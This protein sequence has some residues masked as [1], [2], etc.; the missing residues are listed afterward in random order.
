MGGTMK[1]TQIFV[2]A[3]IPNE[4]VA[5]DILTQAT[6]QVST[7]QAKLWEETLKLKIR[8]CPK[9]MPKFIYKKILSI[10]LYQEVHR[11]GQ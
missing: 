4:R 7:A 11:G 1:G 8:P 6:M 5:E 9:Y 2:R 3:F 10:L